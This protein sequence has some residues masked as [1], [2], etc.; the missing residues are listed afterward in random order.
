MDAQAELRSSSATTIVM[1]L[2]CLGGWVRAY[3]R[4]IRHFSFGVLE[5]GGQSGG[6][7]GGLGGLTETYQYI[8]IYIYTY[9]YTYIYRE[10]DT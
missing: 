8:Y 6:V 9:T 10:R 7:R 1:V 2:G 3:A 5:W 4:D